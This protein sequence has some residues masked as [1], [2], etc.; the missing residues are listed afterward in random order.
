VAGILRNCM[1]KNIAE[2]IA[3]IKLSDKIVILLR[4]FLN[5]I[6]N[7]SKKICKDEILVIRLVCSNQNQTW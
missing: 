7:V 4:E 2:T 1:Q 3:N 5:L 6:R